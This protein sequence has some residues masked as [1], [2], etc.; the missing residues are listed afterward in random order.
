MVRSQMRR[1][2]GTLSCAGAGA[3]SPA[4]SPEEKSASEGTETSRPFATAWAMRWTG[5]AETA[6]DRRAYEA[7]SLNENWTESRSNEDGDMS[8]STPDASRN[9]CTASAP[10]LP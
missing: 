3:V 9:A 6:R 1:P 2:K 4:E 5:L 10:A 8:W 7:S